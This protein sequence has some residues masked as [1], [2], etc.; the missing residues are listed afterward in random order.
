MENKIKSKSIFRVPIIDIFKDIEGPI[1]K[2]TIRWYNP[3][4]CNTQISIGIARCNPMDEFDETVGFRIAEGRA[5]M[6]M[7]RTYRLCAEKA[8]EDIRVR[9]WNLFKHEAKHL[10]EITDKL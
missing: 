2:C 8:I 3:I 10:Q 9:Y 1:I 6:I 4:N 5:K 7:F